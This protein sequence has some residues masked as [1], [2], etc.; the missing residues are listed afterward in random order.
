M[1]DFRKVQ[2]DSIKVFGRIRKEISKIKELAENIERHGLLNPI[3]VMGDGA[4]GF[5]LLAGLRRLKAVRLLGWSEIYVKVVSPADAVE[6]LHV[7]ISENEAREQFTVAEQLYYG[8]LLEEAEKAQA[9]ERM[10]KG[11]AEGGSIAGKGRPKSDVGHRG[12]DDRPYPY[13]KQ[14]RDVI[15]AKIG[16]SGRQYSRAKYIKANNPDV[17]ER[18]DNGE[19]SINKEYDAL[20]AKLK[21]KANAG[22]LANSEEPGAPVD[23]ESFIADPEDINY[24][25]TEVNYS[26]TSDGDTG[27]TTLKAETPSIKGEAKPSS[28]APSSASPEP[29]SSEKHHPG[30]S[31]S[32]IPILS[33]E[34]EDAQRKNSEFNTLS[35]DEKIKVLQE[36]LRDE[37]ARAARAEFTLKMEKDAHHNSSYHSKLLIKNLEGQFVKIRTR[38]EELEARVA[39]LEG[40]LGKCKCNNSLIPT[41]TA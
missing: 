19:T 32:L 14:S 16:M 33:K 11:G 10:V 39:E 37:R 23:I 35:S 13:G 24:F 34:D 28:P 31:P 5:R 41:V 22:A 9:K 3:T 29:Y 1:S 20:R 17:I 30:P 7:E 12:K 15:G 25:A 38:N 40:A 4:S 36:N 27:E 8:G 18:I 26:D 6:V 2:V 21:T